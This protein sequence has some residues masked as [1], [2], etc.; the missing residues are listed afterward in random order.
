[1]SAPS[2]SAAALSLMPMHLLV[3]QDGKIRSAGA[4]M[5]RILGQHSSFSEAFEQIETFSLSDV[6]HAERVFLRLRDHPEQILRG[7]AAITADGLVLFN[8]GF[9]IGV[10][11]AIRRFQLT[12]S[13]FAPSEVVMELLF[14]HEANNAMTDEL[15]KSNLKLEEARSKA[16]AEAFTDPLTGLYNRRGLEIAFAVLREG[17]LVDPQQQFALV[18]VD[19]DHF[20]KLNDSRGH[21]AGDEMLKAVAGRLR[22]VTRDGDII[23]RIGGD[24]F[25]LILSHLSDAA[26][27]V[28]LGER[29]INSIEQPVRIHGR[30][31]SVSASIGIALSA[32][33][34]AIRWAD[35]EAAADKALY[36][37][38]RAGRG[39]V[40]IADQRETA[41]NFV[42]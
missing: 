1:M 37:A 4:T 41:G 38:K 25:V 22:A 14:L 18:I 15:S 36:A 30:P 2:V 7:R 29:I 34:S 17:A 5:L 11:D 24:E 28:V 42:F 16:E 10:I 13:D 19:L 39:L 33:F 40:K 12:D 27:A 20:K 21:A 9:G 35:L 8:L 6:S 23:A 31:S 32:H 3:D 26:R